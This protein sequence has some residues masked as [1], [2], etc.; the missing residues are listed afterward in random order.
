[1]DGIW[2]STHTRTNAARSVMLANAIRLTSYYLL[3]I[4][5][6]LV[7]SQVRSSLVRCSVQNVRIEGHVNAHG[8]PFSVPFR[9]LVE[10]H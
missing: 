1:M 6:G 9:Y 7:T 3:L 10:Y 2:S 4:T 5:P 8:I